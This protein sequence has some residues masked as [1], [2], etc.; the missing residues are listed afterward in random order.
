[1]T[2]LSEMAEVLRCH[3]CLKLGTA[4][5]QQVN[6]PEHGQLN[7]MAQYINFVQAVTVEM[8]CC[9]AYGSMGHTAAAHVL[10][11]VLP[12]ARLAQGTSVSMQQPHRLFGGLVI[13]SDAKGLQLL[14]RYTAQHHY[15]LCMQLMA[16]KC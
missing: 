3:L 6:L 15:V 9:V 11:S 10:Y 2:M 7:Q 8:H 12:I 4:R 5:H 1:M 14:Q 13:N 16:T